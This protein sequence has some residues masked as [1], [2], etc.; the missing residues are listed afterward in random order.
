MI[1]K[2]LIIGA[3]GAVGATLRYTISTLTHRV[4]DTGFP[5]GTLM[6]NFL[7][8]L[9]M[10]V[11]VALAEERQLFSPAFRTFALIGILGAFTT[12]STFTHESYMLIKNGDILHA[13]ANVAFTLASCF[14]GFVL[15]V[16]A[17]RLA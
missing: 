16:Y 13:T 17:S 9:V 10:G 7:G 12:F 14:A 11:F 2:L 3:G 4:A 1:T 15:G 5:L 6:V 8:C